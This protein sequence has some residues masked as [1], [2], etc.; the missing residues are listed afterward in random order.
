MN[1]IVA[2]QVALDNAL[3]VLEKRLNIKKYNMRIEFDKPQR[4]LI[5]QVTL[6]DLKLSPRHLA[7]L[8]TAEN[9]LAF[10]T[11]EVTPKTARKFKKIASPLKKKTLVLEEEPAKK[12]KRAKHLEPAKESAPTKRDV[13]SKKPSRK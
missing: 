6:D 13:S 10:A 11:G 7:F 2:Q 5:F 9:Y 4:E 1:Q 3:V 12:P 8:I